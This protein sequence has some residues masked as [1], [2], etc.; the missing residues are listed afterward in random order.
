MSVMWFLSKI[1]WKEKEKV[2]LYRDVYEREIRVSNLYKISVSLDKCSKGFHCVVSQVDNVWGEH[3]N[4]ELITHKLEIPARN[5]CEQ[6]SWMRIHFNLT[7]SLSKCVSAILCMYFSVRTFFK[8]SSW[9]DLTKASMIFS[10]S[11][12]DRFCILK[13]TIN[14]HQNE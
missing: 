9:V 4:D 8:P 3:P 7:Y 14:N 2:T 12:V 10:R 11:I 13:L 6:K 1:S 5:D